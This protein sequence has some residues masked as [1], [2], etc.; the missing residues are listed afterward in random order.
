MSKKLLFIII[1]ISL[2]GLVGCDTFDT[3]DSKDDAAAAQSFFPTFQGY[4]AKGT[5]D[6]QASIAASLGGVSLLTGNPIQAA[7]VERVDT[8]LTCYRER[9]AAD[10]QI[11]TQDISAV[12]E[13]SIPIAGA[14]AVINQDRAVDNFLGCILDAPRAFDATPEPCMGSGSFEFEGET[15]LYVYAATDMPLCDLFDGHFSAYGGG[16][17]R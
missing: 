15:I 5:G 14:L 2:L 17:T 13:G 10:A 3:D 7:L 9:G 12:L 11:Y 6:I 1:M 8:L 16:L 4:A